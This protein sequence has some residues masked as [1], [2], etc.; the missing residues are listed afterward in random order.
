LPTRNIHEDS[1]GQSVLIHAKRLCVDWHSFMA[2]SR[3]PSTTH[4]R[5][6]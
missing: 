5:L 3:T 2:R 6:N 1:A 4:R